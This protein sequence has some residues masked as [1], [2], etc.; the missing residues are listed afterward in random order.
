[1]LVVAGSN[2]ASPTLLLLRDFGR[3]HAETGPNPSSGARFLAEGR[4]RLH[5]LSTS[6]RNRPDERGEQTGTGTRTR[7][8]GLRLQQ[9]RPSRRQS[10]TA[11]W[12]FSAAD[13]L[14]V[15]PRGAVAAGSRADDTDHGDFCAAVR[16]K[17]SN[18]TEKE[19]GFFQRSRAK[20]R[21][22]RDDLVGDER[23][24]VVVRLIRPSGA[25]ITR[26]TTATQSESRLWGALVRNPDAIVMSVIPER[27]VESRLWGASRSRSRTLVGCLS[28]GSLRTARLP[29]RRHRIPHRIRRVD[30]SAKRGAL[31]SCPGSRTLVPYRVR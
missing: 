21:D 18:S 11:S 23:L 2:P 8:R 26:L 7:R 27:S 13:P 16:R 22:A 4:C 1:V 9:A 12:A 17:S 31:A 5:N 19:S 30:D 3:F 28:R 29:L 15:G 10:R 6:P 25:P 20:A 24:W 14:V